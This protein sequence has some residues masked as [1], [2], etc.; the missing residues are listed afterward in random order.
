MEGTAVV[1]FARSPEREAAAK[2][3]GSA[4]PLF[5]SVIG[6]WL[7][8]AHAAGA[9]AVIAC[10]P[11]DVASLAA[12]APEVP[13][14]WLSQGSGAFGERVVRVT[15][16]AFASG[17]TRVLLAAIDA[18]PP[19]LGQVLAT[20]AGGRPVVGPARDGG[21]NFVGLTAFDAALL[22]RLTFRRCRERLVS[23]VVFR[24]VTDVD[25]LA[26]LGAARNE[27]AWRG[28]FDVSHAH[29]AILV[30]ASRAIS[31]FAG[32]GPPLVSM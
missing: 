2:R 29:V 4:A 5:R 9:A 31:P 32:R 11:R 28:Y 6:A 10:E 20:L 14:G 26:S 19:D 24:S 7:Q 18:P 27:R 16:A 1:L 30:A 21:V 15:A 3:L 8:A 25:D 23:L 22:A 13:R 12:I 17:F